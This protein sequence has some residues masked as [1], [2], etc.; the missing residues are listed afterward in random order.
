MSNP[1][2]VHG[3]KGA[4]LRAPKPNEPIWED[5]VTDEAALP[6]APLDVD[7]V[8]PVKAFYMYANGPDPSAPSQI[9]ASGISDCTCAG[10]AEFFS[11]CGASSGVYP[12]GVHFPTMNIV[13]L[14]GHF[15]YVLGQP[16]TDQGAELQ[17]VAAELMNVELIDDQNRPHGLVAWAQMDNPNDPWMLRRVINLFG[18]V[19]MG[20]ALPDNAMQEFDDQLPFED[21][22]EDPDQNEGHCMLY[23]ASDLTSW[24]QS[25]DAATGELIT[26]GAKQLV[27]PNWNDKYADTAIVCITKDWLTKNGTTVNGV[28]LQQLISDSKDVS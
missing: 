25:S 15:G 14:Y 28:N 26:W 27:S 1:Q 7:H 18:A 6:T 8:T 3:K 23:A 19:Y 17:Q 12:G 9:A 5:Y 13:T 4:N 10:I 24:T 2:R 22:S 11:V 21:T 16:S 20:Y